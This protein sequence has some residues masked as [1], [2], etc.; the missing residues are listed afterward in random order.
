ML[1]TLADSHPAKGIGL[2]DT[3]FLLVLPFPSKHYRID[4]LKRPHSN[5]LPFRRIRLYTKGRYL[6]CSSLLNGKIDCTW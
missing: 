1:P 5:V 3:H 2:L 6:D 4:P